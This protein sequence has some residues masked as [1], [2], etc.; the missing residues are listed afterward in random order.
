M[1][2]WRPGLRSSELAALALLGPI[3]YGRLMSGRSF[4]PERTR[5]LVDLV[6]GAAPA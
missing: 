2:P 3:F 4:E 6:L 1:Q 5:D